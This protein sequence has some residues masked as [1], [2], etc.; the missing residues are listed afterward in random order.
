MLIKSAEEINK[1]RA[2]SQL[3]AKTL[4][5]IEEYVKP[6]VTTKQLDDICYKY[7]TEDLNAIA[8]TLNHHGFPACICTSIN[9]VVC[10]GIPSDKVLKSGDIINID[11]TVKKDGYIGDTSKMYLVGDVEPFAKRLVDVSQQCMYAGIEVVKPGVHVGDIGYAIESCARKNNYT[12]VREYGGHGIG[13][14]MWEDPHIPNFGVPGEG[15]ELK[16]GM[17][18]TIDPMVNQRG[19]DVRELSDGWTIVTRDRKLSAQWEHTLLVT[20]VG[21]EILTLREEEK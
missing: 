14:E 17:T 6:G 19:C 3:A 21:V 7:I 15:L 18:F 13:Q 20:D 9:N 4:E 5:M 12:V 10:H 11:V 1:M 8:S 2:A 16:A